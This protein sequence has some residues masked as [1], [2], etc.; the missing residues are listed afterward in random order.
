MWMCIYGKNKYSLFCRQCFY[1]VHHPP[2][3]EK[4]TTRETIP[5]VAMEIIKSELIFQNDVYLSLFKFC[6]ITC[7]M[8]LGGYLVHLVLAAGGEGSRRPP[9]PVIVRAIYDDLCS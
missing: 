5:F 4:K 2:L 6:L 9:P 3:S 8:Y 1:F 7:G